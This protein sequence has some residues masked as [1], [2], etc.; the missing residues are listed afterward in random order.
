[1]VRVREIMKA[2]VQRRG[3]R[4]RFRRTRGTVACHGFER[5]REEKK[6]EDSIEEGARKQGSEG[7]G[8]ETRE[9]RHGRGREREE[10]AP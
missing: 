10:D 8:E 1:M 7:G 6:G 9:T 5:R 3:R 4:R 2:A